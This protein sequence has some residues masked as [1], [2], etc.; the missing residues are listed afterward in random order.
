MRPI[1]ISALLLLTGALF[2]CSHLDDLGEPPAATSTVDMS[3]SPDASVDAGRP[4]GPADASYPT[5][6]T[7]AGR[8]T[9]PAD[10]GRSIGPADA[11]RPS[12][13]ADAGMIVSRFAPL[14]SDA[15]PRFE[16]SSDGIAYDRETGLY[17]QRY[18][19]APGPACTGVT[20]HTRSVTED[21]DIVED[22]LLVVAACTW[23]EADAFCKSARWDGYS[24]WRLP[25]EIELRSILNLDFSAPDPLIDPSEFEGT[26]PLPFWAGERPSDS[27]PTIAS[28]V[29]F[30]SGLS[31]THQLAEWLLT[32]CVRR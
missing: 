31:E 25:S 24:T 26:P 20:K 4:T 3:K 18:L 5:G 29:S 21:G 17:W 19:A 12:V 22:Q 23:Q 28:A 7:D 32:R 27:P 1:R 13:L 8:P 11:G 15:D 6:L 30:G 10:A 2:S 14:V 16:F 9:G